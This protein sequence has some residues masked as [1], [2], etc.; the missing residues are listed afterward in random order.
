MTVLYF[1]VLVLTV[2]GHHRITEQW[3]RGPLLRRW[4]KK[5][6]IQAVLYLLDPSRILTFSGAVQNSSSKHIIRHGRS[7][8]LDEQGFPCI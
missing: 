6:L 7:P 2:H 1:D 3:N 4:A 8:P 5:F